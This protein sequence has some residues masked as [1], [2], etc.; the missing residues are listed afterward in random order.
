[1]DV[2]VRKLCCVALAAPLLLA[3]CGRQDPSAGSAT[4]PE[5]A[6]G[7]AAGQA[8]RAGRPPSQAKRG[9]ADGTQGSG[10]GAE[11]VRLAPS[12]R[13]I[14]YTASLKVRADDVA[15]AVP[16][17][18]DIVTTAGGYVADE[19]T[20]Q[21]PDDGGKDTSATLTLKVPAERYRDVLDQL[22]TSLGTRLELRQQA[23]DV[24]EEVADTESRLKSARAAL[25]RMRALL[26]EADTLGEVLQVEG[27]IDRREADLEALQARQK[28]LDART[29][30]ATVTLHL[31]SAPAPYVDKDAHPSFLSG[32]AA[33]WK[34]FRSSASA[35]LTALG[36]ALPFLAVLAMVAL[37][38]W[39]ARR[40]LRRRRA[41]ASS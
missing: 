12:D 37:A 21:N 9:A 17:A 2:S 8:E 23:R 24:T 18:K 39:W 31:V 35:L 13:S 1:M 19:R 32:L 6:D 20:S 36:A 14:V 30:Y 5:R 4:S 3:G 27:E 28:S 10:A 40:L 11:Q 22:G 33:G 29:S 26:D 34:A 25:A 16:H 15:A 38:G 7:A 41:T